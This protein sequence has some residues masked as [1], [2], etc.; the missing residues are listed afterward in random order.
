MSKW[1]DSAKIVQAC[2][3]QRAQLW[4]GFERV[5]PGLVEIA[6]YLYP[7]ALAGL[8][9]DVKDFWS[10]SPEEDDDDSARLTGVPFDAFRIAY[11][12]FFVNLT[13]PNHPWFRL[14]SPK[15]GK[16]DPAQ[17]D[18]YQGVYDKLTDATD[19][20]MKWAGVYRPL[21]TLYK[22]LVAFGFGC[23]ATDEDDERYVFARCLRVGTYALGVDRKGRVDRVVE[24][25]AYTAG[26]MIEEFGAENVSET[27][28]RAARNGEI[29]PRFEVWRLIEP[30]VRLPR[31]PSPFTLS[32]DRFK[33]RSVHW[34]A[35]A[36][37]REHGLLAVRGYRIKPIVA[38]RLEFE[39]GDVYGR[40]CG[41]NVVGR[42]RGLQALR[43]SSLEIADQMAHP[44]MMAPA[45]MADDGLR[46]GA[47]DVNYYSDGL[48]PNAV[49]RAVSTPPSGERVDMAMAS[50]EQEIRKDLFNSEFETISAMQD[51]AAQSGRSGDHMTA[52]EVQV[53]V[54]EKMEQLSGIATTLNDE[55]LDPLVTMMSGYVRLS[56]LG[57]TRLPPILDLPP[58]ILRGDAPYDIK[59][60]SAIH[61]A[62]SAQSI[63][64]TATAMRYAFDIG[65]MTNSPDVMD[66]FDPD[67]ATRDIARKLGT[68]E[69]YMR[70]VD[71]RDG[72]RARRA[73]EAARQ[74]RIQEQSV[75]AKAAKDFLS[76]PVA[77]ETIGGAL[78][79]EG[80]GGVA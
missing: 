8:V 13:N 42:C 46:L 19:W 10:L 62:A 58:E 44:A 7:G 59:Y 9:R 26:Q 70:D 67:E 66:N 64:A 16:T 69:R 28:V 35:D 47:Y 38:P 12:G 75:Q 15:F 80:E 5:R 54:N 72:L 27:V 50:I 34:T 68:P 78:A 11:S 76:A 22:H 18:Y 61:A 1:G 33:Y 37:D 3:R 20:L 24:H 56:C 30:H 31:C 60:E 63:N 65:Q 51:G 2:E 32:H 39:A 52:T 43:E 53:R 57:G 14:G 29:A 48:P 6:R 73:E 25:F 21:R 45:S 17:D 79:G 23:I 41:K 71:Y 4:D 49:Y 77:P 55:L 40:G 74:Q 36:K